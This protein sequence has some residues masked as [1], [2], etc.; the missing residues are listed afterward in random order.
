MYACSPLLGYVLLNIII[1]GIMECQGD[2]A[3]LVYL[4]K[5]QR[6][7]FLCIN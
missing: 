5:K 2:Y 7:P 6:E 4:Q 1:N 3:P